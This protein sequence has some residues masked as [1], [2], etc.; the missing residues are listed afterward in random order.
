MVR[1]PLGD[2]RIAASRVSCEGDA[3]PVIEVD[4][5]DVQIAGSDTVGLGLMPLLLEG[6]AG[7]IEAAA[8][9]SA[10]SGSNVIAELVGDDGF[11]E[12][13]GSYLVTSSGSNDAFSTLLEN[14]A[15]IGMSSRRI[16][17]TEARALSKAGA[18]NMV[19]PEQEH[20]VAV[21]SLV[22]VTNPDNPINS[23]TMAQ[24][25]GIY[26]GKITNWQ[27]L[28]G[29]DLAIQPVTLSEDNGTRSVFESRVFDTEVTLASSIIEADGVDR[30]AAIVNSEQGA[31]GYVGYAFQ[32]GAKA[33]TLVNN[34]G[35]S[36]TPDAFSARTEEYA[37][38]RRLYLYNRAD[39]NAAKTEDFLTY[40]TSAAADAVISKSGFIGLGVDRRLQ[41]ADS[42]R[43]RMLLDPS[44]DAYE[45]GFMQDMLTQMVDYDRLST[46]FRFRTGSSKLDERGRVDM[47]RLSN[48]LSELD[49]GSEV[50]FVGFTDDVG[51][52]D[53]NRELS[54]QRA[55]RAMVEFS[56]YVGGDL[57]TLK[58]A[59]TG[60]GEIAPSGCNVSDE[61]RRI[62]RR[63]EVWVKSSGQAD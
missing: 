61:G 15:D 54:A 60:Y 8:T 42:D 32:R 48:Y 4:G 29:P 1:T 45:A 47:E 49:P 24:L 58:L 55:E 38:Q 36:M 52:F 33:L 17:P 11:G 16:R 37:L 27:E 59:S 14:Q 7:N 18:G 12:E 51:A 26:E 30:V 25:Q 13:L 44:V 31:L 46:T 40:A 35:I 43:A 19:S 2:L 34:C 6:Y 63:V 10:G 57:G 5:A 62:N 28:G 41:T 50:L 22:V 53:S 39:V 21:D 56:A 20:I 3:C 9:I 23:L